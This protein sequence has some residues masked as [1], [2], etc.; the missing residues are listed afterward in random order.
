MC[1]LDINIYKD[2]LKAFIF[3]D[4]HLIKNGVIVFDDY[5]VHKVDEIIQAVNKIKK[6]FH[7]KYTIIYNYMGQCIMIKK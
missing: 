1:H 6:E 3:V 2:T 4:K 7:T 5:G